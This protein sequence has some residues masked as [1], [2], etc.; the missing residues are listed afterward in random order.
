MQLSWIN[1]GETPEG[2]RTSLNE[3]HYGVK[4]EREKKGG[5]PRRT[6]KTDS[7]GRV[8]VSSSGFLAP[9]M[10]HSVMDR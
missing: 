8:L 3:K 10:R 5:V 1:S 6:D 2:D 9:L 4:G 7:T